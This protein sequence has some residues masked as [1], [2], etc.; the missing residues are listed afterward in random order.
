M[1]TYEDVVKAL[2]EEGLIE[3]GTE[4][5]FCDNDQTRTMQCGR[6][7][8][9]LEDGAVTVSTYVLVCIDRPVC[10][11]HEAERRA[12]AVEREVTRRAEVAE[13]VVL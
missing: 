9:L 2:V 12:E 1:Q 8:K 13:K 3:Y 6:C 4:V 10:R 7:G 5:F 11:A